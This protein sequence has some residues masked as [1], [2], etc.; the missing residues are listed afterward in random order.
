MYMYITICIYMGIVYVTTI[1]EYVCVCVCVCVKM[2]QVQIE[3]LHISA[4]QTF[5]TGT[6]SVRNSVYVVYTYML[7][8]PQCILMFSLLF[9]S[10]FSHAALTPLVSLSLGL[11]PRDQLPS[12][13]SH[14]AQ[15]IAKV[16]S[17]I[18]GTPIIQILK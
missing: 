7:Y 5:P 9:H 10:D 6:S 14:P 15:H 13:I 18:P 8:H 16:P 12:L 1:R 11:C 4:F 2:I 3:Y 17:L